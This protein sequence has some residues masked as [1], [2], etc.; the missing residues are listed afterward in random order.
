M[1]YH[2]IDLD[3]DNSIMQRDSIQEK[4][5]YGLIDFKN[6]FF[7]KKVYLTGL[8][9]GLALYG[10]SSFYLNLFN[11]ESQGNGNDKGIVDSM[12]KNP[13]LQTFLVCIVGPLLEE[14]IFRKC[15]FGYLKKY[16][17]I[18]AYILSSF[19]FAI[20]HLSDMNTIKNDLI[21]IPS[22]FFSGLLL[23][24]A[25]DLDGYLLS[26]ILTHGCNNLIETILVL[27]K[28]FY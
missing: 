15:I 25:Y 17:N 23:A 26:S 14:F 19:V 24:F 13:I 28:I 7:I 21:Y 2:S 16:S 22:L 1:N 20:A 4:I 27:K 18:L 6:Q 9:F 10:L 8:I 12:K 11:L 5:K 3:N